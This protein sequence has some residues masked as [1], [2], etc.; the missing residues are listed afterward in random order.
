M[1]K[2][3]N[4]KY[5]KRTILI[6]ILAISSI[7]INPALFSLYIFRG[8]DPADN[9]NF[10]GDNYNTPDSPR[11]STFGE[12]PWW[13][14]SFEYRMLVNISN[15]YSYNIEDFGVSV[16]FNYDDLVQAGK[17]Q[18][19]LDDI[20]IIENGYLRNYY[21]VKD[22]PSVNY[23]TV[24]FD[25]NVSQSSIETDTYMYFGN[26]LAVNNEADQPSE[27]FGWVKN[28]DFE[29]DVNSSDNFE[30]FGWYFSH[31]PVNEIM[32]VA[33]PSPNESAS[34]NTSIDLFVNKLIDTPTGG[35]RV[36][37][38]TYAYKWG[39]LN[40]T[41]SGGIVNDYAGTFF[42][43]PFTVPNVDGGVSL[44]YYRNI[45]TFRFEEPKNPPGPGAIDYDGYFIRILNGSEGVYGTNPDNHDDADIDP[46]FGNY[47]ESYDGH[48]WYNPSSKKWTD[49][50]LLK[51]FSVHTIINDTKSDSSADGD[52]T[53]YSE[54]DLT[55]YMGKQVFFEIGVWGDESNAERKEKDA[56]FQVDDLKFNYT[57]SAS[58]NEVQAR[59]SDVTIIARDI[60]GR[61]VPN[62]K[63]A[64]LNESA[65]G[66]PDY[67]V[68]SGLASNLNGSISFK[69]IV[70]GRYNITANYTLGSTEVCVGDKMQ[71][72]NG[73]TY[74][75]ELSLNIW[76]IDFEVVD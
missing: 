22:F 40:P 76:T 60:D 32:G 69:S 57:L 66:T 18:S 19:D 5:Y 73:T 59:K 51:D 62:A 65:K 67:V 20:R 47:A 41:C 63:I 24:Y 48:A 4:A 43:Y 6:S 1:I 71:W 14:N 25:T 68:V 7:Y 54:I 35:E 26:Y 10:V 11:L 37:Q 50:T 31:N 15:P 17:I 3:I 56:F 2:L 9:S 61:I 45:R 30:P 12:A 29:L 55:A 34:S 39:T 8:V 74:F 49:D 23:A 16:S 27:S 28:G 38:G 21:V 75:V 58:L 42:T 44:L 33:N 70:N 13:D 53:G 64:I 46:T 36:A 72:L 52:L